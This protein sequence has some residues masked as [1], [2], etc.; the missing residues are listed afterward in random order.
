M[1]TAFGFNHASVK[2]GANDKADTKDNT[3]VASVWRKE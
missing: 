1:A 2:P 3:F